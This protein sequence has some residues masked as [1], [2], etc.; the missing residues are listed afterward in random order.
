MKT[1]I[2]E[3][4]KMVLGV[5]NK[6]VDSIPSTIDFRNEWKRKVLNPYIDF[7]TNLEV[8]KKYSW[9]DNNSQLKSHCDFIDKIITICERTKGDDLPSDKFNTHLNQ[10]ISN[11][12]ELD[13]DLLLKEEERKFYTRVAWQD[14]PLDNEDKK[15]TPLQKKKIEA[16][17]MMNKRKQVNF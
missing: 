7:L 11:W 9:I 6:M 4:N 13:L 10:M 17:I 15:D 16:S 2:T 8:I 5:I 12:I 3:N 14:E 1:Y